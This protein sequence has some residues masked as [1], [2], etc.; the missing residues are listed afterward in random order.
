MLN[1]KKII[2]IR[3]RS[4][5]SINN[6]ITTVPVG[7]KPNR[8]GAVCGKDSRDNIHKIIH[9]VK[10]QP[11]ADFARDRLSAGGI[12]IFTVV[13]LSGTVVDGA[14]RESS[15]RNTRNIFPVKTPIADQSF[16]K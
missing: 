2:A 11:L 13:P 6:R 10:A 4:S 14:R 3:C 5:Y 15:A 12:I 8:K 1:S 9:P 7:L 16:L